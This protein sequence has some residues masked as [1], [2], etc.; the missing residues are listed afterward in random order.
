MQPS[1]TLTGNPTKAGVYN[2]V[3]VFVSETSTALLAANPTYSLTIAAAPAFSTTSP[4]PSGIVGVPYSQQIAINGGVPPFSF[5]IAGT[6]PQGLFLSGTGLLKGTP[7]TTGIFSFNLSATDSLGIST[8]PTTFQLTITS[9]TPMI[10]VSSTSLTFSALIGGDAPPLQSISVIPGAG[11]GTNAA[12]SIVVDGGQ[13][14]TAAPS[15]LTVQPA[16]GTAPAQLVVS[17]DQGAL[18]AGSNVGRIRVLDTNG[19]PTDVSVTL[20][21]AAAPAQITVVPALLHFAASSQAP[22]ALRQNIAITSSGGNGTLA[23]SSS[24]VGGSSWISLLFAQLRANDS[25]LS[26]SSCRY[27]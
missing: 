26:L 2:N 4:L 19:I 24:V 21:V 7:T 9:A 12:F 20:N 8:G 11:A 17:V 6:P 10:T 25:E 15:W 18:Q 27:R 23:F 14:G 16:S 22:G 13:A 1:G 5:N 3:S